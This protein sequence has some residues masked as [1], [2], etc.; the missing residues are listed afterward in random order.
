MEVTIGSVHGEKNGHKV[1]KTNPTHQRG[2]CFS[3]VNTGCCGPYIVVVVCSDM[4]ERGV[5]PNNQLAERCVSVENNNAR[6]GEKN[7][8]VCRSGQTVHAPPLPFP[9]T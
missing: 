6:E 9:G 1:H 5:V 8:K 7:K 3:F 4:L 2:G